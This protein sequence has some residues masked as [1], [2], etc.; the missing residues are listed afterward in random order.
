MV[1]VDAV[2][3]TVVLGGLIILVV[4]RDHALWLLR[5]P[6]TALGQL[7]G[8]P[9]PKLTPDPTPEPPQEAV[10]AQ[11]AD[12]GVRPAFRLRPAAAS[13][14]QSGSGSHLGAEAEQTA[15]EADA[16][17]VGDAFDAAES[18]ESDEYGADDDVAADGAADDAADGRANAQ[19]RSVRARL[20]FTVDGNI[21][22]LREASTSGDA[23]SS[24]LALTELLTL[25]EHLQ[26]LGRLGRQR[27]V[28]YCNAVVDADGL[29]LLHALSEAKVTAVGGRAEVTE[30]AIRLFRALVPLIWG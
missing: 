12:A 2:A 24:A 25:L 4:A 29:N 27:L 15:P 1:E 28:E 30:P 3:A 18:G 16:A 21:R 13:A 19:E 14:T 10:A 23:A 20:K 5:H 22:W 7:V 11:Q 9:A 6:L 8:Q 17:Q 26:S